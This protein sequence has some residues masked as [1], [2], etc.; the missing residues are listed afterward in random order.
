MGLVTLLRR[1]I[2]TQ[3]NSGVKFENNRGKGNPQGWPLAKQWLA[4][5]IS[6]REL[7]RCALELGT[8]SA[9]TE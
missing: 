7:C 6:N 9:S 8:R 4:F 5:G 1:K 3:H 2:T